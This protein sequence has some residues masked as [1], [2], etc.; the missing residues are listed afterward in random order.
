M[1]RGMPLV[2]DVEEKGLQKGMRRES[3]DN[4]LLLL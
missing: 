3:N 1:V 2:D 4:L